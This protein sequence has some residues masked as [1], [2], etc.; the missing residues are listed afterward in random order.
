MKRPR[1]G[2]TGCG[3]LWIYLWTWAGEIS[4]LATHLPPELPNNEHIGLSLPSYLE[5]F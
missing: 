5:T 4:V 3:A 1:I 2:F